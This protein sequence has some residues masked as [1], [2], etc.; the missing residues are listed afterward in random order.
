[1]THDELMDK[2]NWW[3]S[4]ENIR[5]WPCSIQAEETKTCGWALHS[6][7]Q[8][9]QEA[10]SDEISKGIRRRVARRWRIASTGVRTSRMERRPKQ[11][12]EVRDLHFE[13]NAKNIHIGIPMLER[14]H[15]STGD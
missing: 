4:K 9:D 6:T 11:Q 2:T 13:I 14:I 1:M 12:D 8:L 15:G 3:Q 10:L 5:L 7:N